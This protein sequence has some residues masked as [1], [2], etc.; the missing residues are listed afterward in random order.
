MKYNVIKWFLYALI[1]ALVASPAF[2]KIGS[3]SSRSSI[4]MT[5]SVTS[6]YRPSYSAPRPSYS[7]QAYR[8]SY[9]TPAPVVHQTIIPQNSASQGHST[10]TVVAAG[11]AGAMV[12]HMLTN[13]NP[14]YAAAPPAYATPAQ[15]VMVDNG[16]GGMVPSTPL[17]PVVIQ[18]APAQAAGTNFWDV[19]LWLAIVAVAFI[20][21][22]MWLRPKKPD[23][24][25]N[26]GPTSSYIPP[27]VASNQDMYLTEQKATELFEDIQTAA[28]FEVVS[29][30]CTASFAEQIKNEERGNTTVIDVTAHIAD[31]SKPNTVSVLYEATTQD[32]GKDPEEIRQMWHFV[33]AADQKWR[34]AGIEDV[35]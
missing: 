20:A 10:G 33:R 25:Y 5:R 1:F 35:A 27:V 16:Q 32:A 26:M 13:Q 8:P 3:S 28:T 2:A 17:A 34:L 24:S 23:T 19:I 7:T 30:Y 18:A 9:S 12:G 31:D 6:S 11:L 29:G 4:G 22:V 15:P 14:G 21:L